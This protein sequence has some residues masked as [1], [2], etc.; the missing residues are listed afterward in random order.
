MATKTKKTKKKKKQLDLNAVGMTGV[1]S[2][3]KNAV[4]RDSDLSVNQRRIENQESD[5]DR[6]ER[7]TYERRQRRRNQKQTTNFDRIINRILPTH[8][9]EDGNIKQQWLMEPL[10]Y[11]MTP[12]YIEHN[13]YTMTIVELYNRKGTNRELS[14]TDVI[15]LIPVNPYRNVEMFFL[16][17]DSLVKGDEKTRI[18]QKNA[19]SGKMVTNDTMMNG[20]QEDRE[21][22]ASQIQHDADMDDYDHYETFLQAKSDPI[23]V[24]RICLLI[25]GHDRETVEDQVEVLNTL[26]DQRNEGARWDSLGGD[27]MNRFT[28]MFDKLEPSRHLNT[29]TGDNY[30]GINFAV[31]GGLNDTHGLPVGRDALALT[32]FTSFFDMSGTLTKQGIISI[33]RR[34]I[35]DLYVRR[36]GGDND[37]LSAPP[38]NDQPSASSIFAQYAANHVVLD[39]YNAHHLVL[40]DFDYFEKGLYYRQLNVPKMYEKYDVSKVTINPLQ[41]FGSLDE[42]TAVYSRLTDKIVNIFDVMNNLNLSANQRG[43]ILKATNDF[44]M[45]NR[46][47]T[48]DADKYPKRT[49]IVNIDRPEAYPVMSNLL[50]H[51]RTMT[52]AALVDNRESKADT[53]ETLHSILKQSVD[54]HM[55]ILGRPTA[56][57][58]SDCRQVYYDF[59]S[60][61]SDQ[62]RQV[63]FLNILEYV[64]W[65]AKEGDV[66]VIHGMDKLWSKVARMSHPAIESA[67]KKGIRFLFAFDVVSSPN[68][69]QIVR[70]DMF[71][72]QGTYYND[73][74]QDVDWS[75]VGT[76]FDYEVNMY[77]KALAS[78]LS[79]MIR[80]EL[81]SKSRCKVLIHRNNGDINTFVHAN[82]YV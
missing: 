51:L 1:S 50:T 13:G 43:I 76:C 55:G 9:D 30:A 26:L 68:R 3:K 23:V 6:A 42:V 71:E 67:Q 66:V 79:T 54:S 32:G 47:W 77:E 81:Q 41:G 65:T 20:S 40:N 70:S 7:L 18:V 25:I 21:N 44:Y 33:P 74:D 75:V 63:Q 11:Y 27:Q 38:L 49:S 29:S 2:R 5:E 80:N 62:I 57:Q 39:G 61:E 22:R 64:L 69:D 19:R 24:Y 82:A 36:A 16:V 78:E 10:P 8:A 14:Y 45:K 34:S 12:S 60:I 56:I 15:E 48:A 59:N 73:L 58:P 52:S 37:D 31:S 28:T 53:I 72:L 35:L 46:L 4:P 17:D